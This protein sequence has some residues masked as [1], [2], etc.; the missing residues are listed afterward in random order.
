MSVPGF[1]LSRVPTV[2]GLAVV[3]VLSV[4]GLLTS[5]GTLFLLGLVGAATYLSLRWFSGDVAPVVAVAGLLLA[6][7]CVQLVSALAGA[8]L[9]GSR[10][11]A[12]AVSLL[13]LFGC[14]VGR[15]LPGRSLES[16]RGDRRRLLAF[17]PVAVPLGLAAAH[18]VQ[19][20]LATR[21]VAA[22]W[23][24]VEHAALVQQAQQRGPEPST[25][26]D[27][28]AVHDLAA[29]AYTAAGQGHALQTQLIGS[30]TL[31][32]L[33][34]AVLV[35]ALIAVA[36]R[37]AAHRGVRLQI[38]AGLVTGLCLI[39]SNV[40]ATQFVLIGEHAELLALAVAVLPALLAGDGSARGLTTAAIGTPYVALLLLHLWPVSTFVAV[41]AFVA[42]VVSLLAT[43]A[44]S[45]RSAGGIF[46][47]LAAALVVAAPTLS[48]L[49]PGEIA[50]AAGDP[51]L[52]GGYLIGLAGA[53]VV[54]AL[55]GLRRPG[56][57]VYLA[58]LAGYL[59]VAGVLIVAS[60]QASLQAA[61]LKGLW[62]LVITAIPSG[63][64]ALVA[65][66]VLIVRTVG[67]ATARLGERSKVTNLL[68]AV[69]ACTGVFLLNG[70]A[71]SQFEP[72][73]AAPLEPPAPVQ[74]DFDVPA[75]QVKIQFYSPAQK[76]T[77]R[78]AVAEASADRYQPA[79]TLPIAV[80]YSPVFD[81][82]ASR[83]TSLLMRLTTGQ[84]VTNGD[85]QEICSQ[86]AT[87]SQGRDV[88]LVTAL[89]AD[90]LQQ[91][92]EVQGCPEL[93]V[94]VL[95]WP[96]TYQ[97]LGDRG[98]TPFQDLGAVAPPLADGD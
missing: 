18:L 14:L 59:V 58:V 78:I 80:G 79:V 61:A 97:E 6:S 65:G 64:V 28:L 76:S 57:G 26:A 92:L 45:P 67:R 90:V 47:S 73:L 24:P 94:E 82:T 69:V 19:P 51:A 77:R 50:V 11:Q 30:A 95:P 16:D 91:R 23:G 71:I 43:R 40:I 96:A 44:L 84:R 46:L 15:H 86:A 29:L 5:N 34:D 52:P 93:R 33:A 25:L 21:W 87:V 13:I 60:G 98:I 27:L 89:P 4:A 9:L 41:I 35:W 38:A 36:L 10:P 7:T 37:L 75:G 85:V 55:V 1:S 68:I 70:A 62:G 72:M 63:S 20:V 39:V 2:I 88:V 48:A 54:A 32:Y 53:G 3:A 83:V 74:Q 8:N 22:S 81:P 31:A 17:L 66:V 56:I 42:L 49:R 12:L